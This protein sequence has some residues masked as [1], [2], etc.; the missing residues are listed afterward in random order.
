MQ[1][2]VVSVYFL[3]NLYFKKKPYFYGKTLTFLQRN[4]IFHDY[5]KNLLL[6]EIKK[7]KLS[8]ICNHT[9]NFIQLNKSLALLLF[10]NMSEQNI[11]KV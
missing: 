2:Y 4:I 9:K 8:Y 3:L 1:Q 5:K 11:K 10:E 6:K 7:K